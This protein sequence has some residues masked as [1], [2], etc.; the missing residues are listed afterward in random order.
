MLVIFP[1]KY[2][3]GLFPVYFIN[4]NYKAD[5]KRSTI[6]QLTFQKLE[7]SR[8]KKGG[9]SQARQALRDPPVLGLGGR[10]LHLPTHLS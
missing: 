4:C 8:A 3:T 6:M 7:N 10:L 9:A 5:S 2:N 1:P